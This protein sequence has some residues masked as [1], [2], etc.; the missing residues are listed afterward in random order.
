MLLAS[1]AY[2]FIFS[3][4]PYVDPPNAQVPFVTACIKPFKEENND[5]MEQLLN[6][7]QQMSVDNNEPELVKVKPIEDLVPT[8]TV[9]NDSTNNLT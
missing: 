1:I 2:F 8:N 4:K 9:E 5:L 7:E 3:Y 6:E